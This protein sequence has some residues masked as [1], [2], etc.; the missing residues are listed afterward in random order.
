MKINEAALKA[1]KEKQN[2]MDEIIKRDDYTSDAVDLNL[3]N[4]TEISDVSDLCDR[5]DIEVS[6]EEITLIRFIVTHAVCSGF[7]DGKLYE[8]NKIKKELRKYDICK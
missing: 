1:I 3:T 5:L 7:L 8:S 4:E 6:D 2:I